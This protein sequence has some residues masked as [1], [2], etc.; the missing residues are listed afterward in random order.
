MKSRNS[1]GYEVCLWV[2]PKVFDDLN[3]PGPAI[4]SFFDHYVDWIRYANPLVV[5]FCTGN[6]DHVLNYGGLGSWGDEFDWARGNEASIGDTVAARRAHNL[7]W[8]QH[9]VEGG[10]TSDGPSFC[11]P[12]FILSEQKMNFRT[13]KAI[14]DCFREEAQKRGI[15]FRIVEYIE[16]GPEFCR[17]DWKTHLH[18]EAAVGQTIEIASGEMGKGVIDVTVQLNADSKHYASHP[19]GIPEGTVT[20]DFVA[21]QCGAFVEEMGLDG[22][23]LGNQ[24]GLCGLWSPNNAPA[25]T[26]E[27]RAGIRR[28]F[29][30]MRAGMGTRLIYWMDSYWRAEVEESSWAMDPANYSEMDAI[31]CSL[32]AVINLPTEMRPNLESKLAIGGPKILFSFDFVDPWYTYRSYLNLRSQWIAQHKLYREMGD[33]CHGASFFAN[34]TFGHWVFKEP[35]NQTLDVVRAAHGWSK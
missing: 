17:C 9:V 20:G 4:V 15:P 31:L 12:A 23:F 18:P 1:D 27:R 19:N 6:G 30:A 2:T 16:P 14:Y 32:F 11:G 34:D 29:K 33:K 26:E 22:I 5:N 8:L 28:F 21:A 7:R 24:F 35:L 25:A 10:Q 13:L 3:D